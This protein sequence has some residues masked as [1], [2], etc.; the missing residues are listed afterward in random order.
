MKDNHIQLGYELA[1][2]TGLSENRIHWQPDANTKLTYPCVLY[3]FA[4]PDIKH[5]DNKAYLIKECY[6][7]THIYKNDQNRKLY[8]FL[9][10]FDR[11]SP[12]PRQVIVDG[13]YHDYYTIYF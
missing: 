8:E 1:E 2:V 10:H 4:K 3:E 12:D 9:D 5:A 7:V 13:L 6:S 11:I